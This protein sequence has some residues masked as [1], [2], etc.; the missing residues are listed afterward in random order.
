MEPTKLTV[1][2]DV[3]LSVPDEAVRRCLRLLETWMDD[4]PDA[5]IIVETLNTE[6][7]IKHSMSIRRYD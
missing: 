4:N 2:V 6:D 7:G 3:K 1:T 5:R